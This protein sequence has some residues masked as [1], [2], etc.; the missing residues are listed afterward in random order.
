MTLLLLPLLTGCLPANADPPGAPPSLILVSLDTVRAD[1]IGTLGNPRGLTPNLDA[2]AAES[3]VFENTW[4]QTNITSMSHA[5]IFTSRYPSELGTVG[6]NFALAPDAAPT[7]AA[8]LN[9]YGYVSAAFTAG[10]HMRRGTGLEAGFATFEAHRGLGS[11]W[12]TVPKALAW[13]DAPHAGKPTFLLVHSYD[14]HAPYASP[15]PYGLAWSDPGYEGPMADA[16]A[17]VPGT[18]SIRGHLLFPDER[19]SSIEH[20]LEHAR[21]WDPA[22]RAEIAA[23]PGATPLADADEQF[24]RDV[25][26]SAVAYADA[27]FGRLIAGLK[28]DGAYDRSVIVVFSD[29]GESL[30]EDGRFGHGASLRDEELRVPLFIH[31]PQVAPRRVSA[32]VTLLDIAPTLYELVRATAPANTRGRSLVPWLRGQV[33]PSSTLLF[34]ESNNAEVSVRSATGRLTFSGL[35]A[36]SP[37]LTDVMDQT[38][39]TSPAYSL[40]TSVI[41]AADK[42]AMRTSLVTWRRGLVLHR[43]R[44]VMPRGKELDE[45]RARGYWSPG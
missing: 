22:T 5:S 7:L 25:Y 44:S 21:L 38:P 12:H 8:V 10:G 11:F 33:G 39:L 24:G 2:F 13:L 6:A 16:V 45:L 32:D 20:G 14:A 40:D 30:G 9:R 34:A 43:G 17:R 18:E 41:A 28:A 1:R 23:L 4:A 31:A 27:G 26:D 37:W 35:M 42:A 29:H 36:D 3:V 15:A 19:V